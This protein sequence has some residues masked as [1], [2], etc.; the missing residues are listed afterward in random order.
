MQL[1]LVTVGKQFYDNA[2]KLIDVL[3]DA[4][5]NPCSV[6]HRFGPGLYIREVRMPAGTFAIGHEQKFEHMNVFIKG[7]VRMLNADGSTTDMVAPMTFVGKPGRKCGLILEDVVWQNIYATDETDVDKLEEMFLNKPADWDDKM[8]VRALTAPPAS[9]DY[10]ALL[11]DLGM[12]EDTVQA[13]VT[14]EA[15]LVPMP[16]GYEGCVVRK[17]AIH[18]KGLFVTVPI[19]ENQIIAPMRINGMRTPA[20]RYTNHSSH[21]NADVRKGHDDSLYLVALCNL[22]GCMG[23]SMGTEVTIDYR[24]AIAMNK[25]V[26]SCQQ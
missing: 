16:V 1:D 17:S 24:Q 6:T 14:N 4:P 20:G 3:V 22:N 12:T 2:E 13:E 7:A 9:S 15:D 23:G 26:A 10:V 5:Q 21:P 18:G 25:E 11:Q 19:G 8:Q